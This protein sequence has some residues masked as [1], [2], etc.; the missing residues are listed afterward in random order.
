MQ[1]DTNY[2]LELIISHN[3]QNTDEGI[4]HASSE[5]TNLLI[6]IDP[7]GSRSLLNYSLTGYNYHAG[8]PVG[9][10]T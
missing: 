5:Y 8:N 4:Q 7:L 6:R 2:S 3:A 9:W 10:Q 1:N